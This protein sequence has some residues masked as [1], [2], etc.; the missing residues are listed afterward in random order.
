MS[1]ASARTVADAAHMGRI[2]I[3]MVSE[4]REVRCST[5][6]EYHGEACKA[7][8]PTYGLEARQGKGNEP[9]LPKGLHEEG[10]SGLH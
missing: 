8:R 10:L 3:A 6:A 5:A 2:C 7:D 1:A 4:A 9:H